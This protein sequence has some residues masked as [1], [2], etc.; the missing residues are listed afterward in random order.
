MDA[1]VMPVQVRWADL[2]PNFHL[3]HSVYYDWGAM[4]RI[5]FFYQHGLTAE[6]LKEFELGPI[7]LREECV[8]R[9]EIRPGD[10]VK[11]NLELARAK[12][13]YSRWT[14]RHTIVKNDEVTAALL[15]IDG[16]WLNTV[17]RKMTVPPEEAVKMLQAMPLSE[18]FTWTDHASGT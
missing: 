11:M 3:R 4:C 18:D 14:I 5:N 7:I 2:D 8:F 12:R 13:D 9:K 16:A 1:F 6:V 10:R 15:T 17:K